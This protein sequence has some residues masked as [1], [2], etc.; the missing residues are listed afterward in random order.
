MALAVFALPL[1]PDGAV[2][3][4][5]DASAAR[6]LAPLR[7][8]R[9]SAA[10]DV[11]Q[12][13]LEIVFLAYRSGVLLDAIVR[14]LVRLFVTRRKL[15]EWE[16]AASTEQR[17]GTGLPHFVADMWPA[18]A[19]AIAIGVLV[20]LV[21]PGGA[22]RGVAVPGRLARSPPGRPTASAGPAR[23]PHGR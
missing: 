14:T 13:L 9:E 20:A 16:T 11:G 8:S 1:V 5:R 17:L 3:R 19:L 2:G 12:V 6:S 10:G 15:L 18:P 21:Q 7:K 22:G 23:W 4:D